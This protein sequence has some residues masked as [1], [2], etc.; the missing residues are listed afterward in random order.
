MADQRDH[1]VAPVLVLG[2][3]NLLLKDDGVGLELLKRLEPDFVDDPRVEFVDGGTQGLALAPYLPNR[4]AMLILDAVALGTE[5]GDVHHLPDARSTPATRSTTA[6]E[7]N[8]SELLA[9]ATLI[10]E[11]PETV[12][13]V[14]IEPD[15]VST[16][17]GLTERVQ[18]ALPRA[19]KLAKDTLG[20][21]IQPE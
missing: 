20:T 13:L 18:S 11:C 1:G 4:C 3:G 12:A 17:I 21:L 19:L 10:G 9:A 14:G 6:H 2:L 5:P 15:D 7:G 16:G 8:A